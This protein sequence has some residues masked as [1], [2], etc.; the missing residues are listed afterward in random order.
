[1]YSILDGEPTETYLM[2]PYLV[3]SVAMT[4][5]AQNGMPGVRVETVGR[6][7]AKHIYGRLRSV[8]ALC[9]SSVDSFRK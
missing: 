7:F 3:G 2:K 4:I 6:P 5:R 9:V 8:T 1:M